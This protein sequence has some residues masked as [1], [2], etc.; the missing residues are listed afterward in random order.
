[1]RREQSIPQV[2]YRHLFPNPRPEDPQNFAQHLSKNLVGEVRI[3]TATFY[4]SLDTIEARYP[5]LNYSYG[6]HRK[7]LGRFPHHARLFRAFDELALTET[8]IASMC[9]WEGTLWARQRYE[10]DEGI[11]VRDTTGEEIGPWVDTRKSRPKGDGIKVKT[12]IEVEIE[13]VRPAHAMHDMEMD[14]EVEE[15]EEGMD[16]GEDDDEQSDEEIPESV[17]FELNQRLLQAAAMREQGVNVP[18]DPEWEQFLKEQS[19]R[20]EQERGRTAVNP[21]ATT[22]HNLLQETR[23]STYS[24]LVNEM[25]EQGLPAV[26]TPPAPSANPSVH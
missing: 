9:R 11:K 24:T 1:M 14:D 2:V 26:Q 15:E 16:D 6:P 17:G 18:M 21:A 7:R 4:G 10:Q 8:E 5:G 19:E 12:D 3:E 22:I 25:L 20:Q 23:R 13:Q